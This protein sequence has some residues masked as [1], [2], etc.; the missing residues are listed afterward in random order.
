MRN[1]G[2]IDWLT[3]FRGLSAVALMKTVTGAVSGDPTCVETV[4]FTRVAGEKLIC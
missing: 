2:I 4:N 3:A 1:A